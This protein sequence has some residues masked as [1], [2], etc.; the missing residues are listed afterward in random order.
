LFHCKAVNPRLKKQIGKRIKMKNFISDELN[1]VQAVK[2][3]QISFGG[4]IGIFGILKIAYY[5]EKIYFL[6]LNK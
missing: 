4:A 6:L 1:L 2:I 5:A 3:L